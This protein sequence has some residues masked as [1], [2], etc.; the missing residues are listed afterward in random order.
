MC[1]EVLYQVCYHT[2]IVLIGYHCLTPEKGAH[3][4]RNFLPQMRTP[5]P[6]VV[7]SCMYVY[8]EMRLNAYITTNH[9]SFR[10]NAQVSTMTVIGPVTTSRRKI[11]NECTTVSSVRRVSGMSYEMMR[12]LALVGLFHYRF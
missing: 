5:N 6:I 9:V 12:F 1:S 10:G 8:I 4:F 3:S 7:S 11:L 2:A